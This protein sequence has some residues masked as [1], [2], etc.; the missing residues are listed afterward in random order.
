MGQNFDQAKHDDTFWPMPNILN[1]SVGFKYSDK[2]MVYAQKTPLVTKLLSDIFPI[3][4]YKLISNT[5]KKQ[6]KR[7]LNLVKV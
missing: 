1:P 6:W 5:K 3:I 7:F 2:F 4:T